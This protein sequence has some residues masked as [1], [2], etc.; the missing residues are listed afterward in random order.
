[1]TM[2]ARKY[3]IIGSAA[4]ILLLAGAFTLVSWLDTLGLIGFAQAL[5]DEYVTGTA[6]TIIVVLL[7]LV[8]NPVGRLAARRC[9]V[10]EHLLR[11]SA[12]YCPTC[13]SRI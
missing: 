9:S 8:G 1:M 3:V 10:C 2:T 5:R 12:K 13:G 6:L 11:P 4:A 7:A